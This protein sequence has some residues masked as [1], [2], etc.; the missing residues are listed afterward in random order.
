MTME[1]TALELPDEQT[2]IREL[3]AI[4]RFQRVVHARLIPGHDY[5][6]IPGTE[7]PT[8]LK[9]G[10]E[11]IS[12]LLGLADS[13]E[14]LDR[15]EDW[16][17]G[18][19][20]YLIRCNLTHISSGVDIS[21]GLGECNSM[22]SKYHWREAKR[23]CPVCGEEAIIKGKDEYGGG[24]VC[25]TKRGGCGA[26]FKAGD[27]AI[28]G[29]K[30]GRVENEDICDLVN[31]IL[32]MAKKRALVDA[33]LSAGR[34]S[35]VFTQDIEEAAIVREV[36]GKQ[37]PTTTAPA[38]AKLKAKGEPTKIDWN[39]FWAQAKELGYE[40]KE[41]RQA[42]GVTSI[43]EEWLAQGKTL[44]AAIEVLRQKQLQEAQAEPDQA[45]LP[46]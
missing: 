5:G 26:K 31:T 17:K 19:F 46:L 1:T 10:A 15:Q 12:K 4:N 44:D 41:I 20:R 13:Y 21:Q 8:L 2:F 29:Q 39:C 35:D 16:Q 34:L 25:F 33:A 42:L 11:K 14:I 7:K 9:P 23:K 18:F 3:E 45:A 27:Q 28:E 30:V 24:W 32:K 37:P 38:E 36:K 22:E 43:K 6:I 40:S